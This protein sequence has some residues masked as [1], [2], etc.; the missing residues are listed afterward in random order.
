MMPSSMTP[1]CTPRVECSLIIPTRDRCA[2]LDDTLARI[3]CLKDAVSREVI[4]IDNGSTDATPLLRGRWPE[5]RWIDAGS[6]LGAAARNLG[7]A[8]ARGDVLLMLDDDSWPEEG[9][10]DGLVRL[11][12]QAPRLGAA[13][14]RVRLADPPHRHD[15]GGV[16][17]VFF[18]CGGAVRR[19]AFM[20]AG[21]FPID[22][23]YFVEEYDLS[24]R[25]W[26]HGWRVDACGDLLVWHRRTAT[27]RDNNR[28]LRLLVRNN[29]WLWRYY[30]PPARRGSLIAATI[31]RYRRVAERENARDGFLRGLLE[32]GRRPPSRAD[33]C[34][35]LTDS[36]FDGL[37]G[38]ATA[39]RMLNEWIDAR[40]IRRAAIWRR[41]KSCEQIVELLRRAD[42]HVST[43]Y[44]D[45]V[46]R[47]GWMGIPV[48]HAHLPVRSDARDW[49]GIVVGSLSPGV[50]EDWSDDCAA[51]L[52]GSE[53]VNLAP[54]LSA[55]ATAAPRGAH[56]AP[57]DA[58]CTGGAFR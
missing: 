4:V 29:L 7:A 25:L 48:R 20:D 28:M 53:P 19:T 32:G 52:P 41:G 50:A 39:R 37:M 23:D 40:G 21:G 27:N 38:L 6:N 1:T 56:A 44:D 36:Q 34:A 18:N 58:T 12:A 26:R 11:F 42:V 35:P 30:A 3:A 57:L 16:P 47:R 54:W 45:H 13:A 9:T 10:I 17:G 31:E 22:F 43:V 5:V 49:D 51:A 33:R 46:E 55:A 24:C 15:A 8:A 2:E 14:C